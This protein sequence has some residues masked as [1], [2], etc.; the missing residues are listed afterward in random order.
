MDLFLVRVLLAHNENLVSVFVSQVFRCNF[1]LLG[2]IAQV[3]F[4]ASEQGVIK[5]LPFNKILQ[6]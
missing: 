6:S 2:N 1:K 4:H 5:A 3:S